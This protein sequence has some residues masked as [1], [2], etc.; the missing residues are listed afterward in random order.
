MQSADIEQLIRDAMPDAQVFVRGDDGV[1][2]DAV[3]ISAAFVGK[4]PIAQHRMVNAIIG[5]RM[6]RE[7]IHALGLKT[8]T[9]EAWAALSA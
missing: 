1:H 8:Y 5:E 3:V 9:P 2:F 7:E 6:Q 4:T